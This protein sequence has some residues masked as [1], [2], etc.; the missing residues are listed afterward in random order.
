MTFLSLFDVPQRN[1]Y[2]QPSRPKNVRNRPMRGLDTI[3]VPS[4]QDYFQIYSAQKLHWQLQ[5]P[6]RS[7][8]RAVLLPRGERTPFLNHG[9]IFRPI[10]N[11]QDLFLLNGEFQAYKLVMPRLNHAEFK[12]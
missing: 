7:A 12:L 6:C 10:T 2:A 5:L 11:Q 9:K 1:I 3:T 4:A 8:R